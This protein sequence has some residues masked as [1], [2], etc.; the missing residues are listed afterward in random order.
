MDALELLD[1]LEDIIDKG[2]AVPFS[3]RCI[4]EKDELLDILQEIKLKLPDDLKQAKWIKEERNRII[5]EAQAEAD[6]LIKTAEDKIIAMVNENEITKKAIVQ[7]NQLMEQAR[8]NAQQIQDS[9]YAYADNLLETVEKVVLSSM[10][11]MEQCISIV[12]NNRNELRNN[13][14]VSSQNLA[15]A[16]SENAN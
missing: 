16:P 2:A 6:N 1:E 13:N 9:S 10:K 7:G 4:L 8:D 5:Q 11:D 12:R 14:A 15:P 3:G